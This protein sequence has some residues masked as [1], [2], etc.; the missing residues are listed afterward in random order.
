MARNLQINLR[1][2]ELGLQV[3]YATSRIRR[4]DHPKRRSSCQL[5]LQRADPVLEL[6]HCFVIA[7]LQVTIPKTASLELVRIV[8]TLLQRIQAFGELRL[9]G[10][11]LM[12]DQVVLALTEE[13]IRR[14]SVGRICKLTIQILC[15]APRSQ[16]LTAQ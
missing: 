12:A 11:Q 6:G 4:N 1:L 9:S 8:E 10:F 13:Y 5:C 15:T 14:G 3:R 7:D 16:E 2:R